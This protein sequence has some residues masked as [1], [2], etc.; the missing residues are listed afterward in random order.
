ML[1]ASGIGL[2]PWISGGLAMGDAEQ[3]RVDADLEDGDEGTGGLLEG[4][5]GEGNEGAEEGLIAL[6][7]D[8]HL[9]P[10]EAVSGVDDGADRGRCGVAVFGD[11]GERGGRCCGR[12]LE[13]TA[14]EAVEILPARAMPEIC[15]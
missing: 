9:T 11:D 13:I 10:G 8:A 1:A 5:S 4:P 2:N 3:L 6:D 14:G 12:W 7:L 15:Q